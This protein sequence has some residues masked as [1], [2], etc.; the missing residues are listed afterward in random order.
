MRAQS[1]DQSCQMQFDSFHGALKSSSNLKLLELLQVITFQIN[2]DH[3][4]QELPTH[5]HDNLCKLSHLSP[6]HNVASFFLCFQFIFFPRDPITETA[7]IQF[8]IFI[9]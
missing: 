7:R 5:D 9:T 3:H 8:Y 4:E 2:V 6:I 1:L